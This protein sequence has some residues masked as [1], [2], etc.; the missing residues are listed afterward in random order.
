MREA[1]L[2]GVR[3][4]RI[5][6]SPKPEIGP[7]EVLVAVR[8]CGVCPTD[9]R[10]FSNGG[11]G[12]PKLPL[13]LGHEWC[14]DVVAIGRQVRPGLGLGMR[15]MAVDYGGYAEYAKL[16]PNPLPGEGA[17]V[18]TI[19]TVF[20][21]PANVSYEEATL[22]EPLSCAIHAVKDRAQVQ[23][24]ETLVI[25]GAG[26]MGLLKLM[27][28]KYVGARVVIVDLLDERLE[29][30]TRFGADFAL[31]GGLEDPV[32]R[33]RELTSGHGADAVIVSP[34]IT[35]LVEQ[36]MQM[37]GQKG[38]VVLFGG[39]AKNSKVALDPNT[40]HYGEVVLTGSEGVG[41][42]P[43]RQDLILYSR[44]LD[45]I[46]SGKVLVKDLIT[47]RFPLEDIHKAFEIVERKQGLKAVVTVS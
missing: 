20:E 43:S 22:A 16:G 18:G 15:V 30:A 10:K 14:G 41:V 21:L 31:N 3:D 24:G 2:Y 1:L 35:S 39:F 9:I 8:A 11:V 29:S 25:M 12:L 17:G 36:A 40:I 42:R 28:A 38:R 33:V 23:P 5:V 45:L 6:D 37:V 32:Q 47:H 4:L 13:N 27:V 34:G 44:A 19:D 7:E 46:A 26:Q